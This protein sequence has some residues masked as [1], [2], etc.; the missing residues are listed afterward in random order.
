MSIIG[1][2]EHQMFPVFDAAQL[3]TAKRFASGPE[4][5]FDPGTMVYNI[6]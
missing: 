2:R 6:G 3:E 4:R 5:R 1:T